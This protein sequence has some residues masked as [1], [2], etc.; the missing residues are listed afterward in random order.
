MTDRDKMVLILELLDE[1]DQQKTEDRVK[2]L[3]F[4]DKARFEFIASQ[5]KNE[6]IK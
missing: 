6:P 3:T 4:Q 5:V 2:G 1:I